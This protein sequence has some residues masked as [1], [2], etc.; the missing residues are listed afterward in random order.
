MAAIRSINPFNNE[1]LKE[2]K[3]HSQKEIDTILL[4][5]EKAYQVWRYTKFSERS[6]LMKRCSLNL[7]ENKTTIAE[8]I[9]L[10]MGKPITQ[11][12]SEVEKCAASCEFY[13]DNAEGFLKDEL[14]ESDAA[15][16]FVSFEPLGC[17]LAVMPWNFPLWQVFRFASPA[18]MAGN[19]ALLKHSSNV[20]QCSLAIE[21]IFRESGFPDYVFQTLLIG[22]AKVSSLI[23]H[24]VVKATTLTGSENAGSEV[25]MISGK[26]IKKSV[27]ELGGSDCFIVLKDADLDKAATIAVKS[28]MINT[29]QSCI[30]AKRFIIEE[31]IYDD[32]LFKMKEN[33]EALKMGD[34]LEETTDLG[35]LARE[36]LAVALLKQVE[37]SVK[38]G[39]KIF[40]GGGRPAQQG[41]FVNPVILTDVKPGTPAYEEE[42]FGPV[43]IVLKAKDEDDA[44]RIANDSRYG[45]GGSIW[46]KNSEKG[47]ALARR[48]EAGTVFI[49][50]MVKSDPRLPFGGIKKSGYGRELS[51]FGIRE[52]VNIKTT[53]VG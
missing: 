40:W 21:N 31:E 34:P 12:I 9:S 33:M 28:R 46:T 37:V 17:I 5:S 13:A 26:N 15:K 7:L 50:G 16:S 19:V 51:Y 25:A 24:P 2:Y 23:A 32:F 36:D 10:E 30:A 29:G 20:P 38:K 39:A 18:L 14:I 43:A 11:A 35:P 45:L 4:N 22:S 44:I 48:L 53:W 27:L 49:N 8:L 52:F 47:M 3:E 41:A 42:F 6:S 1:L